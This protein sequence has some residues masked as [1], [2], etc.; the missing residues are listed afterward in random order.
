[1]SDTVE[2]QAC[3]NRKMSVSWRLWEITLCRMNNWGHAPFDPR[4]LQ[5]LVCGSVGD[6][7]KRAVARGFKTLTDL[8]RI[9]PESTK[10]CVV[11]NDDMWRRG[12]GKGKWDDTCSEPSHRPHRRH[13]WSA[14]GGWKAVKRDSAT[15]AVTVPEPVAGV[16]AWTP[17]LDPWAVKV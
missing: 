8:G 6:S 17:D 2:A 1:M 16:P 11:V 15:A 5:M 12:A 14:V 13:V 3:G 4:E 7:E 9:S 10:L